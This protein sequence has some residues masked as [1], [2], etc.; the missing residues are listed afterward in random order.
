MVCNSTSLR[1]TGTHAHTGGCRGVVDA[2]GNATPLLVSN[3]AAG[4]LEHAQAD[5]RPG[6]PPLIKNLP[7]YRCVFTAK[8]IDFVNLY[9]SSAMFDLSSSLFAFFLIFMRACALYMRVRVRVRVRL[10]VRVRACARACACACVRVRGCIVSSVVSVLFCQFTF[11]LRP[12]AMFN[13]SSF[14]LFAFFFDFHE[15]MHIRYACACAC[16]CAGGYVY[17]C[18]CE[19]VY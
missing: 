7:I 10:R 19:V 13:L 17:V 5:A 16:A 14:S 3:F 12:P 2:G 1:H 15:C 4:D 9:S 11:E 8:V 18:M 6:S